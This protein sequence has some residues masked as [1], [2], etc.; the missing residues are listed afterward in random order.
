MFEPPALSESLALPSLF[1]QLQVRYPT[2]GLLTELVQM[3]ADRC[4]VRAL[5]QLGNMT[6]ATSMATATTVEQAEDQARLRVLALLGIH[7]TLPNVPA[8]SS[9]GEGFAYRS[10]CPSIAN[11]LTADN[12]TRKS[13]A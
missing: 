6:L 8:I 7:T 12:R 9:N 13:A 11:Q 3:D 5:V 4:V 2:S 10:C 1:T